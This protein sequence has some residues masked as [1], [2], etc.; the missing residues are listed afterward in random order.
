MADQQQPRQ[1]NVEMP[2]NLNAT[3]ANF[4]IIS[5]SPSEVIIDFAQILPGPGAAKARVQTRVLMT[6]QNAKMLY[7]ALG[8]NLAKF[9]QQFGPVGSHQSGY[10]DPKTGSLG[11]MQWNVGNQDAQPKDDEP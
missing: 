3:Y 7:Q 5:H 2:G 9:E 1:V 8:H 11:G 10:L 4:A 6:P